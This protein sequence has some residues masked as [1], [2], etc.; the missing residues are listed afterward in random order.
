MAFSDLI[1]ATDR[2]AHDHLGAVA[3]TYTPDGGS[4]TSETPGG[5]P[6][7]GMFDEAY[8]IVDPDN[9]GVES[10]APVLKMRLEDLPSDPRADD[11]TIQID[12]IDYTV[13]GRH[14]D[15]TIGGSIMLKLHV[16]TA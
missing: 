8:T 3:V 16:V 14:T 2:A 7:V 4:P 1:K 9:P 15:G 12:G 10:V 13:E 6:L 5:D 11:P